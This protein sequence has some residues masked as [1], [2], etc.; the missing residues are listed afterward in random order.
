MTIEAPSSRFGNDKTLICGDPK[1]KY[2]SGIY[3]NV[4]WFKQIFKT[5]NYDDDVTGGVEMHGK[6]IYETYSLAQS[7]NITGWI[8]AVNN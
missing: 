7:K 3:A 4:G 6:C 2:T 8:Q 5:W 1:Y